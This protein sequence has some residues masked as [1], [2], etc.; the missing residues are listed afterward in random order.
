MGVC[1]WSDLFEYSSTVKKA[2]ELVYCLLC[3]SR[4]ARQVL[5][6]CWLLCYLPILLISS[7]CLWFPIYMDIWLDF[8]RFACSVQCWI[9]LSL[10]ICILIVI[11]S[12]VFF[13]QVMFYLVHNCQLYILYDVI[14]VI[15]QEYVDDLHLA[16]C[17]LVGC[18][19][20]PTK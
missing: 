14:G 1:F 11:C 19:K 18:L 9:S 8:C 3:F 16:L 17:R 5:S 2:T 12:H 4:V 13:M 10:V 7:L 6:R 20:A 15:V